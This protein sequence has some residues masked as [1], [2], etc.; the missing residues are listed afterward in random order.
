MKTALSSIV[1]RSLK[2]GAQVTAE[3]APDKE[4]IAYSISGFSKSGSALLY[5]KD[6]KIV[7]STR[8]GQ[9]D[10]IHEWEDLVVVA[11]DW[12]KDY[13]DRGYNLPDE[14]RKEFIACNFIKESDV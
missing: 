8:Y 6:E 1:I 3:L 7:C 5:I 13:K 4:N 12:W 11:F 10:Y 2:N 9:I 14:W